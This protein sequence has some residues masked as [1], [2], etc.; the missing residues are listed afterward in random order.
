MA[1][2]RYTRKLNKKTKYSRLE[3]LAYNLGQI[4]RGR[5]HDTRVADA[6]NAGMKGKSKKLKKPLF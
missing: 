1:K 2:K 6:F 5:E 3:R 4:E